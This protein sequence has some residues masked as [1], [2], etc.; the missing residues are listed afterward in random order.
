MRRRAIEAATRAWIS[1]FVVHERLCPFAAASRI[2]ITVDTFGGADDDLAQRIQ[3][4]WRLDP[5]SDSGHAALALAAVDRGVNQVS[6]LLSA[7]TATCASSNLFIVWPVG[8]SDM[9]MYT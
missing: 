3:E 9:D 4:R 6:K 5:L 7:E 8:L 2:L 1:R